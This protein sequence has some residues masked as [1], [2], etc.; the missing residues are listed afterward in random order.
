MAINK[1][2][3]AQLAA[4]LQ[5][6]QLTLGVAESLTGGE[7]AAQIVALPGA[8]TYFLG[9]V[10]AYDNAVKAQVLGVDAQLLAEQGA[11]NVQVAMQMVRGVQ[12]V[13]RVQVAIATTGVAGPAEL[14]GQ[15][16]G[17]VLVAVA[18][19]DRVRVEK[20]GFT[21]TRADVR[22]RTVNAAF[23]LLLAELSG[24]LELF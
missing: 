1:E 13:L 4:I 11:V 9:A 21:G 22:K 24:K 7:I 5:E 2:L 18:I 19:G 14:A 23:S 6:R 16:P 8:S 12:N 3:V 17:T 15:L 10:V 20:F